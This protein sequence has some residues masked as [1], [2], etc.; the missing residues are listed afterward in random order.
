MLTDS[1]AVR[2]YLT[3]TYS[4]PDSAFNAQNAYQAQLQGPTIT[5]T[6]Q[7]NYAV[8]HS[9]GAIYQT[10]LKSSD[11]L[12]WGSIVKLA[13][14]Y[15]ADYLNN[16]QEDVPDNT[17][18]V[19]TGHKNSG[20]GLHASFTPNS[21]IPVNNVIIS[22]QM[23]DGINVHSIKMSSNYRGIKDLDSSYGV[24]IAYTD[25][26]TKWLKTI[27]ISGVI[28]GDADKAIRTVSVK[29]AT[30]GPADDL[31]FDLLQNRSKFSLAKNYANGEPVRTG[32]LLALKATV[33]ANGLL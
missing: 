3:G 1:S 26:S 9:A 25:G 4:V 8:T 31:S 24:Q 2:A 27:P 17:V 7:N 29:Y 18:D 16:A 10:I 6:D 33:S 14:H 22:L 12:P 28:T 32:D 20:S 23:P 11:N 19:D 15:T 30:Y 5:L 13:E 21:N